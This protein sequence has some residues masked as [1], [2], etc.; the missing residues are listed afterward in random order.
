MSGGGKT[1]LALDLGAESGRAIAGTFDGERLSLREVHR[2]PNVPVRRGENVHWDLPALFD[3]VKRGIAAAATLFKDELVSVGVDTWGV[4]YGLLDEDGRLMGLPHQ[5]RDSRTAGIQD[6]VIE[7]LGKD[8]LYEQ[9]GIQLM[10]MNSLYQLLAEPPERLAQASNL[11]FIPDLINYWLTG[12]VST[13]RTFA[14]TSQLYDVRKRDWAYPLL[15]AVGLPS[16]ML[17][18]IRDAGE[19]LGPLP[20]EVAEETGAS[21][22]ECGPAGDSRY[23]IGGGRGTR[24]RW[25]V[26]VPEFGH[27]VAVGNRDARTGDERKGEG[28]RAGQRGRCSRHDAPVEEHIGP[29]AR[30]AVQGD[31]GGQG[32]SALIRGANADGRGV[33]A[34][35]C[36]DRSRRPN[37]HSGGGHACSYCGFLRANG[38]GT[39]FHSRGICADGLGEPRA[40][41]SHGAR[42][43]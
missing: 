40:Q 12:V 41:V 2:F 15:D 4:D 27:V 35:H 22:V 34:V 28:V 33:R 24:R 30:S 8:F 7:R 31:V 42:S 32:H 9:T 18:D 25:D 13:E 1:Y 23:G 38:S 19:S 14:S 11:L 20:S 29:V 36:Y 17:G 21:G 37:V 26:G 10:E 5:Y 39:S 16:H 43:D 3:E 6:S